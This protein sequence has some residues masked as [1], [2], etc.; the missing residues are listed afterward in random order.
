MRDR[1]GMVGVEANTACRIWPGPPLR[2]VIADCEFGIA[3]CAIAGDR[4]Y[5]LGWKRRSGN[6]RG[7]LWLGPAHTVDL[8]AVSDADHE[9]SLL[10]AKTL[11]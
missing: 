7:G 8:S 4:A 2:G 3:D 11:P 9:V 10:T 6:G 5:E 1:W